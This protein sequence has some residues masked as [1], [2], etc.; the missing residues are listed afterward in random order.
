MIKYNVITLFP[1]LI[2]EYC[3]TSIIGRAQKNG[4]IKVE[5]INPRIFTTDVHRSVDDV[6]YG[7][8][9]GMVLMCDPIFKAVESIERSGNSALILTTPQGQPFNQKRAKE[10][11]SKE[12]LILICGHYE[13][14]DERIRTGLKPIEVSIGDFVLTGGELAAMCIIDA[15]ARLVEGVLGKQDSLIE[16]SFESSLLEYP[17]YTRPN[18][19][20]GMT[21]PDVITSGHHKNINIWRRQQAIIRTFRRRPDLLKK[22]DLSKED[23]AFLNNY[24]KSLEKE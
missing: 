10:L 1:E 18:E 24:K 17:Q 13:G 19:Y 14:F 2:T 4:A 3:S 7:G 5:T 11:S 6:P 15:T 12:Q 22:S 16:E 20:R 21:V 8:G 9:S 23:I